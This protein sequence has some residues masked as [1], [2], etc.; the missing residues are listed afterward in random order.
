MVD[1][2]PLDLVESPAAEEVDLEGEAEE[3]RE[4]EVLGPLDEPVEDAPAN[5]VPRML[6]IDGEGADLREVLPHDVECATADDRAVD[7]GNEELLH[8]FV[9][10]DRRL[11]QETPIVG[12]EAHQPAYG[13]NI[14][15]ARGTDHD[16]TRHGVLT[17]RASRAG[18]GSCH[19]CRGR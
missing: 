9:E 2:T 11:G 17:A 10:R 14:R 5:A 15:G 1:G 16:L 6:G 19:G 3:P 12:V 4:T 18:R 13:G 7:L 8:V